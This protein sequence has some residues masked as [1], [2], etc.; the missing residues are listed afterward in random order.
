MSQVLLRRWCRSRR[1]EGSLR[2]SRVSPQRSPAAPVLF[3]WVA[4]ALADRDLSFQ[5][6]NV[7]SG[8]RRYPN[9]GTGVALLSGMH[10]TTLRLSEAHDKALRINLDRSWRE[11]AATGAARSRES[12]SRAP[13]LRL[14]ARARQ[15]SSVKREIEEKPWILPFSKPNNCRSCSARCARS[16]SPTTDS[17]PKKRR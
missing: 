2:P 16:R 8:L 5:D 12:D 7:L 13:R 11:L 14:P 15:A 3:S 4:P 9:P 17:R 10:A 1:A 6:S